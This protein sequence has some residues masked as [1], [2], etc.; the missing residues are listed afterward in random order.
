MMRNRVKQPNRQKG[1]RKAFTL[2]EVIIVITIL[3]IVS[4]IGAKL[5]AN[6]YRNYILQRA[7]HR[8]SIKTELAALEIANLLSHRIPG[9]EIARNPNNLSD[10]VL[11]SNGS[12]PSD[13][14]HTLLEWI[15]EDSDGFSATTPPPWSGFVDINASNQGLIVT[16]GSQLTL[17]DTIIQKLS[18]GIVSL[19]RTGAHPAIFFHDLYYDYNR[20]TGIGTLYNPLQCMGLTDNNRSCI[21]TVRL[22]G[23]SNTQLLFDFHGP[24]NNYLSNKVISEHYKLAWSAYSIF[25]IP[26]N[27]GLFNLKLC[28]DYQP[29]QGAGSRLS[30]GPTCP[31]ALNTIINNVSVFKFAQSGSTFRF[32][33]CA[34]ENIGEDYNVTICKE[35]AVMR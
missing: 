13:N 24:G 19:S 28:Y 10:N 27:N 26:N 22:N 30:N 23:N 4:S 33:I 5:I 29:W 32:K 18:N 3:G 9:T 11:L 12:N 35:K 17:E 25:Q 21:S 8:A 15:G 1:G 16:P 20:S 31:G 2:L 7:I 6:V 34:Q 14:I